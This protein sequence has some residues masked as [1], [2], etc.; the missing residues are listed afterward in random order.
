MWVVVASLL[1]LTLLATVSPGQVVRVETAG[2]LD[3]VLA[4]RSGRLVLFLIRPD[5]RLGRRARPIDFFFPHDPQ[6]LFARDVPGDELLAGPV[7]LDGQTPG[8]DGRR[9]ATLSGLPPGNYRAQAAWIHTRGD[10]GDFQLVAG[11]LV[12]EPETVRLEPGRTAVL[13]LTRRTEDRKF[14]SHVAGVE[15]FVIRSERLSQHYNRDFYLRVGVRPPRQ[16]RPQAAYPAVFEVP[17]FGGDHGQV[18]WLAAGDHPGGDAAPQLADHAFYFVLAPSSPNGHT[19]FLDSENNGPWTQAL[20]HELLP[21][22]QARY[23]LRSEPQARVLRGHS[24][25]GW[26]VLHLAL[27]FPDLFGA[28]WA[29]APDP[30]AFEH[31]QRINLYRHANAYRLPDGTETP[32]VRSASGTVTMTVRQENLLEHVLGPDL[33]SAQQWASWQACF[34]SRRPDGGIR[35]LFDPLT[36]DIDPAEA[37]RYRRF[38]LLGLTRQRPRQYVP[39]W[40]DRIRLIVGTA[41]DFFL[42]EA[43]GALADFLASQVPPAAMPGRTPA[44][45][46]ATEGGYIRF[47]PAAT[48]GSVLR[49]REARQIPAEIVAHFRRHGLWP[50]AP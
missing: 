47:V 19:L 24:S 30:V 23:P 5:A 18:A 50:P 27:H 7:E 4:G 8:F 9:S 36:G 39:I 37:Q 43:I 33:S 35:P 6:P 38:D 10:V 42:D 48:H 13:R 31:F 49:S 2:D 29:T 17:G 15:E 21:A 3:D 28:A 26:T 46:P 41:D 16:L 44:S 22:L 45:Q 25:G 14:P 12:S 32:S 40:K 34:G 20:I 11:N 1:V